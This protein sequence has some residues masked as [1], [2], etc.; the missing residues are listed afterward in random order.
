MYGT[1]VCGPVLIEPLLALL[2]T[3]WVLCYLLGLC[4]AACCGRRLPDGLGFK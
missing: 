4:L 1:D 3:K 2:T